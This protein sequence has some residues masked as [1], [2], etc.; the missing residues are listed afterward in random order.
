MINLITLDRLK[1]LLNIDDDSEDTL[2]T[3]IK[4]HAQSKI[5]AYLKVDP[6]S[7]FPVILDWVSDEL[8]VKR[9]NKLSAEGLGSEGIS[10]VVHD[11]EEDE[12][13][14][15]K[16]VLDNYLRFTVIDGNTKGKL[17]ML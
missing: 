16:P 3:T 14:E 17:V 10:G 12:L 4:E 6:S 2:L 1:I 11:F 7:D 15:Y 5:R 9:Y 13:K 8:T